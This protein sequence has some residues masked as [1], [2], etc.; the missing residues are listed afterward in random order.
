[1][2]GKFPALFLLLRITF[3]V[4]IFNRNPRN[5]TDLR[6]IGYRIV[7]AEAVSDFT[8]LHLCLEGFAH[9]QAEEVECRRT[10]VL[11]SR[12]ATLLARR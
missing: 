10:L 8:L 1:M 4:R 12:K 6:R 3:R 5:R 7:D 2:P 9:S 11:W